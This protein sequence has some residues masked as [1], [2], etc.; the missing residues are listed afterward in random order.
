MQAVIVELD[1]MHRQC[2]DMEL[3]LQQQRQDRHRSD[4]PVREPSR[5][6]EINMRS[7]QWR[8]DS[9]ALSHFAEIRSD[10]SN[11]AL[12]PR[13][14]V[15]RDL[16][17]QLDEAQREHERAAEAS[18]LLETTRRDL[19][20]EIERT[21]ELISF[22]DQQESRL[23]GLQHDLDVERD[24]RS[25]E[26]ATQNRRIADL[27][28]AYDDQ[29]KRNHEQYLEL[30]EAMDDR[31]AKFSGRIT[32][33][34]SACDKKQEEILK[35]ENQANRLRA[36]ETASSALRANLEQLKEALN[37]RDVRMEQMA[38]I[39]DR[40]TQQI[41]RQDETIAALK[42]QAADDVFKSTKQER[43]I[44]K[45]L[46][47]REMLNIAVEQLQIHIQLVSRCRRVPPRR[48]F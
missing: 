36:A 20:R 25:R 42:R 8:E 7:Q 6:D 28:A 31:E 34:E 32:E 33:L 30:E 15:I 22:L 43:R 11:D 40:Q 19:A 37:E 29:V 45:L 35:L 12:D 9:A 27:Q 17:T 23:A 46:H 14:E 1:A 10:T 18:E 3:A 4:S 39:N 16:R 13:E 41:S 48:L 38:Q 44:E 47:D 5:A 26:S 24:D 2:H 21:A